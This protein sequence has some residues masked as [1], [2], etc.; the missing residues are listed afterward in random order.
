MGAGPSWICLIFHGQERARDARKAQMPRTLPFLRA[1]GFR[2]QRD[3]CK[4]SKLWK[5]TTVKV[6]VYVGD[7]YEVIRR[8]PWTPKPMET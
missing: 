5:S 1:G 7:T 3:G 4:S 6:S 2:H 8:F